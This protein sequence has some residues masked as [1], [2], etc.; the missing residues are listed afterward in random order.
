MKNPENVQNYFYN[1]ADNVPFGLF[2]VLLN[3]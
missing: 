2:K 3:I 1:K